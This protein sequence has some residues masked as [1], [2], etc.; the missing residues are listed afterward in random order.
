MGGCCTSSE[1]ITPYGQV[2]TAILD[3]DEIVARFAAADQSHVFG[4]FSTLNPLEQQ[5]L[6]QEC[7]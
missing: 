1:T 2:T 4:A 5:N 3:K 7:A 6:L